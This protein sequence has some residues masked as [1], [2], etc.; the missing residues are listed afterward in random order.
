MKIAQVNSFLFFA[1]NSDLHLA[2]GH[3]GQGLY[4]KE[5]AKW[6][7]HTFPVTLVQQG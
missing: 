1:E 4:C 6:C 3:L 7:F 5:K 2:A